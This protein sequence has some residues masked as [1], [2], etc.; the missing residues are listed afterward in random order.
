MTMPRATAAAPGQMFW[1]QIG[2][3]SRLPWNV[4]ERRVAHGMEQR[5]LASVPAQ[6]R[7]SLQLLQHEAGGAAGYSRYVSWIDRMRAFSERHGDVL[8]W[9]VSDS[10][11]CDRSRAIAADV[12]EL[13]SL[14]PQDLDLAERMQLLRSVC[15]NIDVPL[16]TGKTAEG[17]IARGCSEHWW[18]AALR[19]KVARVVEHAAIKLGVVHRKNG[20]YA[21]DEACARRRQQLER[22]AALLQRTLVRNEAGQVYTLA[23]LAAASVSNRDNRRGELMT[24]IRGCEEF[25]DAR[26]HVG[27][28]LTL[29][30]P[31]RFHAV[32]SG[33]K[34]PKARPRPNPR[35]EGAD[36]REAQQ[37]LC[38]NWARTRSALQRRGIAMYGFRV[39]EPHHDG[40]PHW[41]VL[42]W[43][44]DEAAA[45]RIEATVRDY[46]L[47][48]AGDEPG[49]QKNRVDFKRMQAGGA[50][51]YVA[52]YVAKNIGAED[53]SDAGL[54]AHL[55]G[56]EVD[57]RDYKGFQR[58]D[59]WASTW[60]I[61][62]FQPFGQPPVVVW[63][64]MRRVTKDQINSAQLRM[65]FGDQAAVKAWHACQRSGLVLADWNRYAQA[66]G[67]MCRKR[68]AWA[69]RPAVRVVPQ[70]QNLYGEAIDRK[71][72]V[73]VELTSGRWLVSRRQG[74]KRVVDGDA[75]VQSA[76]QR[77]ALARPWTGFNNCTAR[78][79][80]ETLRCL[81][82][83]DLPW[84][85]VHDS[86]LDSGELPRTA[87]AARAR[88]AQKPA[89]TARQVEEA[90]RH[91]PH[92]SQIEVQAAAPRPPVTAQSLAA[93]F[94]PEVRA[95]MRAAQL[96]G[97]GAAH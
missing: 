22:N 25:A 85:K 97:A 5:L 41:H 13:M 59:A 54:G 17:T 77:A 14:W 6:W 7:P 18:R 43:C 37:W 78:L 58:V 20:G 33:G 69:L 87:I 62:Q 40:C 36:P 21:S 44:D 56:L 91:M 84:P 73:G 75:G 93:R 10:T 68:A 81:L 28:F 70:V 83:G 15:G 4:L 27:M 95:A 30:C 32:L 39:A 79:G 42:L 29:T 52:K 9:A 31:S 46:W 51:G 66:Q 92:G 80:R 50:A 55:D 74:W 71:T 3:K 94:T 76:E 2:R 47:A 53:G 57:T 38:D 45:Q 26:G 64:E 67:G 90:I 16:P 23:E 34:G 86:T 60:G 65:D 19:K 89:M 12:K 82:M 63:R 88:P 96:A 11:V 61:R 8:H 1:S 35:Y 24:R 72:V 49:A 48:D